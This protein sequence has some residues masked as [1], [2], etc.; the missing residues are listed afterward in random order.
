MRI[1]RTVVVPIAAALLVLML[2]GP[3]SAGGRPDP[4]PDW[5]GPAIVVALVVFAAIFVSIVI[6][7]STD[8][9]RRR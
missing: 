6:A 3:A 7:G 1:R 9:R 8:R 4:S 5:L 2:A